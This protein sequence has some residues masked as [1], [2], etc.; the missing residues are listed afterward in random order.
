MPNGS[1]SQTLPAVLELDPARPIDLLQMIRV[2]W[3]GKWIVA[4]TVGMAVTMA[5]Y[6][7][8]VL[9]GPRHAAVTVID[10]RAPTPALQPR[11]TEDQGK[12]GTQI[13]VLLA[14]GTLQQVIDGLALHDDP[15]FNRYLNPVSALSLHNLRARLRSVLSGQVQPPPDA[16]AIDSKL[17]E[18]L[19]AAIR[20]DHPRDSD[21]LRITVTT[22]N[23]ARAV[24][25]ANSLAAI[26]LADQAQAKHDKA[27]SSA[28]WLNDQLAIL[29]RDTTEIEAAITQITAQSGLHDP[30]RHDL[31]GRQLLDTETR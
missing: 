7:G 6:Y 1:P 22:G 23:P 17:V 21:L 30:D 11:R 8:F 13:Q 5:G 29:R 4:L 3:A 19:R 14:T 18:N 31:L 12:A 9:A 24:Q 15:A 20:V 26:Y 16:S 2:I 27:A 25:I 10:L 28:A